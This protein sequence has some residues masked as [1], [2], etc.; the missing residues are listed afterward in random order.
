MLYYEKDG[1]RSPLARIYGQTLALHL[2]YINQTTD[3]VG[4][5]VWIPSRKRDPQAKVG[6]Y[7]PSVSA[8][9]TDFAVFEAE[10][11]F[12]VYLL[13]DTHLHCRMLGQPWDE[14]VLHEMRRVT[15]SLPYSARVWKAVF[16]KCDWLDDNPGYR[17][18]SIKQSKTTKV[19][20]G[21]LE[22]G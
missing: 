16:E 14:A 8:N 6:T 17:G 5:T 3:P 21:T 11:M 2:D 1:V 22:V 4:L 13:E 18:L 10:S 7:I 15:E 19:A 12:R 9:D 20:P